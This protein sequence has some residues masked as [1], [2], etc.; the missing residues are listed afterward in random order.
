ML[1]TQKTTVVV[2]VIVAVGFGALNASAYYKKEN[3]AEPYFILPNESAFWIPDVGNN[4]KSQTAFDSEQYLRENK[5]PAKRFN[6]PHAKLQNSDG[7][8]ARDYFVPTG[9]L[10]IVNRTPYRQHSNMKAPFGIL[11]R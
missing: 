9:R 6:V 2:L 10:I 7:W 11:E 4:V 1:W 5:I 8:W 3:Y